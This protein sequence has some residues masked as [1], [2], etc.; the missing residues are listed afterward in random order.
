M[1]G[2]T[3]KA[4]HSHYK[5]NK[6]DGAI[7]PPIHLSS[8]FKFENEGGYDY[9]RTV[10][11]TRIILEQTL[12]RLDGNSFGL[13]YSSGSAAL[14]N[15]V[16]LLKENETIL[17]STDAYGGTYRFIVRVAGNQG[18][19]YKIVDLTDY[20]QTESVLKAGGIKII[21]V[22]TPTNPLLKVV[23]IPKLSKLAKKYHS[24][25]VVDNTFASPIIQQPA[26]LG[27]DI[28][29]YSTTK[30]INGHSDI[31]GGALTTSN[32]DLYTRLKFLQN[33][34]GAIL[35]PFDSWMTLR[36]L[37]TLEL[38]MHRHIDNAQKIAAFLNKHKKIKKV[39]YPGLFTGKQKK[40]VKK[41]MRRPGG[42]LSIEL[43]DKYDVKKFLNSLKYFPLAESLGG[44]E[45]LIDHPASMTHASIPKEEREK[46]GLTESLLRISVGIENIEDLIEDLKQ[47]L[48]K[49]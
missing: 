30:Y 37:R 15:I 20:I 29:V 22:E 7:I 1:K 41:Q 45:S 48:E 27:A 9:S 12:A 10:N 28:V 8:T 18:I 39:Y 21:W 43:K 24:L 44:V 42:M 17:F 34:I 26:K 33:A 11:P 6:E 25:L 38:R 19:K 14:A 13:A 4:L 49:I 16:A 40:I 3:T 35:S 31:I 32:P 5:P 46:I 2:F 36:G 23:D 47:A